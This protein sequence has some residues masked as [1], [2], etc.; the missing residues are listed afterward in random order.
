MALRVAPRPAHWVALALAAVPAWKA[1]E[2]AGSG[3]SGPKAVDPEA[4]AAGAVLFHREWTPGDPMAGGD[5]LGPVFNAS[6]CVAC[7]FQGGPGG[8]G[9]IDRNVTVF[10]LAA[11]PAR[12]LPAAG[13]VHRSAT[14]PEYQETLA[15]VD[16]SLPALPSLSLDRLLQATCDPRRVAVQVTQRN[17]PALFGDGLID[18]ITEDEIVTCEREHSTAARLVGLDGATDWGTKGRVARL[19]DGRVGRF[20]WKGEFATLDEFVKAACANELGLSNPSRPQPAP[21]GHPGY[22]AQGTDLSDEQCALMTDFLR[23]LPRPT[24]RPPADPDARAR[25]AEGEILFAEIGCADCHVP[26]LGPA[27]GL[28]SDLLLHDMGPGLESVPGSYGAPPVP[29]PQ[30]AADQRPNA[31][32]WRT[33]P[34]WGVA[35]SAPYL[36]DGRAATLDDAIRKHGGEAASLADR[37]DKLDPARR[38]ALLAF[39]ETLKAPPRSDLPPATGRL[40][41]AR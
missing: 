15:L 14:K 7:H 2:W 22:Q 12:G 23:G 40:A 30:F 4:A 29:A 13:V 19:A 24:A 26:T 16:P 20:G 28:Y 32:E 38:E 25:A 8:G 10:G 3:W 9:P 36:H 21:L 27:E 33:P 31:A 41:L 1:I 6:S 5:G 18:A 37:Y 11:G 39:L 17:T 34:L 35:D